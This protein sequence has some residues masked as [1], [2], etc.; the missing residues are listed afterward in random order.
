MSPEQ[1]PP[2]VPEHEAKPVPDPVLDDLTWLQ[3]TREDR[4]AKARCET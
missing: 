1:L 4:L 2:A 3:E